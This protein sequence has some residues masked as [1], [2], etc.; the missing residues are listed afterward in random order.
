[1]LESFHGS[2]L[3]SHS[4]FP[5]SPLPYLT[6]AI[7]QSTLDKGSPQLTTKS[8]ATPPAAADRAMQLDDD[9]ARSVSAGRVV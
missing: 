4:Q 6:A 9:T 1:M 8:A 7:E 3:D 2:T 5:P